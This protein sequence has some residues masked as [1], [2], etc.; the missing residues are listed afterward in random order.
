[1]K[2]KGLKIILILVL[3]GLVVF[4]F[5]KRNQATTEE[6][7]TESTTSTESEVIQTDILNT[8]SSSSYIESALEEN[9]PVHA[10]YYLE[11]IYVSENQKVTEGENILK[12]TNGTYMTAPYNGVITAL[13]LP[14]VEEM[15]TNEHFITIQSTDALKITLD[16]E[17]EEVKK[18]ALGEVA[19]I[20]IEVL[21]NQTITGYVTS[22]DNTATYRS[23]G[24]TFAVEVEF[25][26]DGNVLLGMS[27][28]CSI[29]LEKAENVIGV[30]TEAIEEQNGKTYVTVKSGDNKTTEVQVE[31]GISNDAYTEIKSGLDVG[32]VV[33][34]EKEESSTN[35]R[36]MQR[37][38]KENGQMNMPEGMDFSDRNG[39][40][41]PPNMPRN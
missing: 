30:A 26:N 34:I 35:N 29:I 25:Q 37:M 15:C 23:S 19:E 1:M 24:S 21:P 32:D 27:A 31:T 4:I 9:K 17:E 38:E 11:E 18:V 12:Y 40:E 13:S 14:D 36:M 20:A 22:I 10:T 5:A 16:V 41:M 3:I 39:G 6:E 28:K 7:T 2:R 8:V 33:L